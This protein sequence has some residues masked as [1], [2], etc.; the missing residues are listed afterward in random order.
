MAL[1]CGRGA[2]S[3]SREENEDHSGMG[4]KT[5]TCGKIRSAAREREVESQGRVAS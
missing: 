4:R 1:S 2:Q 3:I 5:D